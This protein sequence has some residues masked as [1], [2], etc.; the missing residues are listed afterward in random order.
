VLLILIL[1]A[2]FAGALNSVR[3]VVKERPIYARERSAGLS[4][5]AYLCSKLIVLGV[6][7]AFQAVLLVAV[8]MY[9]TKFPPKGALL[10]IPLV[11]VMLSVALVGVASMAIGL[12][13]SSAVSTAERAMPLVFLLVM[14][15]V[16]TTGGIF[17]I[18]GKVGIEEIAWLTPSRWGFAANAATVNLNVI[19]GFTAQ[20]NADPLW[21]HTSHAWLIDMGAMVAL[22]IF[23]SALTWWRLLKLGPLKRGA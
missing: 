22:F 20:H 4:A 7:S 8:G 18:H 13:V 3:E 21:N 2:C 9:G 10:P 14:V 5:G 12:L 6:I 17:P 1:G 16:V 23:Y 19:G 15:Q 11:E